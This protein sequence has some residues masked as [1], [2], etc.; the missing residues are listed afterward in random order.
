MPAS[1]LVPGAPVENGM[2][3]DFCATSETPGLHLGS[4]SKVWSGE[5]SRGWNSA[6][7]ATELDNLGKFLALSEL[8]SLFV[9]D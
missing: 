4:K 5:Q 6:L 1:E 2:S 8:A 3:S 7:E 9:N